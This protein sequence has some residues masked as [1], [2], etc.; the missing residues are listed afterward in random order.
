VK[1][2]ARA[3]SHALVLVAALAASCADPYYVSLGGN[4]AQRDDAP[5]LAPS[6]TSDEVML[7]PGSCGEP[8]PEVDR[9]E[10]S[11]AIVSL[12]GDCSLRTLVTC[13]PPARATSGSLER[14]ALDA[15]LT[16][17]FRACQPE[18]NALRVRFA[19]G[20]AT[21][22]AL[23]FELAQADAGRSVGDCVAERLGSERYD[24][25]ERIECGVGEIFGVPTSSVEPGW[26]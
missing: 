1:R 20:C 14:D 23:D 22:Y 8:V 24:C 19:G 15:L 12:A 17:L 2:R 26:L 9:C 6:C 10:T 13:P 18:P 3:P 11:S 21:S 25:A 5:S 7:I 4:A 16:A